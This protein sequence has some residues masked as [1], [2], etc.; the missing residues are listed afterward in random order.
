MAAQRD[1]DQIRKITIFVNRSYSY[2]K[3]KKK[4]YTNNLTLLLFPCNK[5]NVMMLDIIR[6]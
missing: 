5:I 4:Y 2:V 6:F 3:K 1:I